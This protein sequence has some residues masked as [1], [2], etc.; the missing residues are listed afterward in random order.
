MKFATFLFSLLLGSTSN[1]S[2]VPDKSFEFAFTKFNQNVS[3]IM[4]LDQWDSEN[5]GT[6][7]SEMT[8]KDTE[9][10]LS[11]AAELKVKVVEIFMFPE[12]IFVDMR[13][14]GQYTEDKLVEPKPQIFGFF[15]TYN[16]SPPSGAATYYYVCPKEANHCYKFSFI[17][18]HPT[19]PKF[20]VKIMA[21]AA[22][23]PTLAPT[24]IEKPKTK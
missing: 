7:K 24:S 9:Y 3:V 1:A 4:P 6:C 18:I 14:S 12:S 15:V 13:A 5:L 10:K 8:M 2:K 16:W 21:I 17:G 23:A 19:S 11:C 20:E 22:P